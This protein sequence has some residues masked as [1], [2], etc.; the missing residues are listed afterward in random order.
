VVLTVTRLTAI[1]QNANLEESLQMKSLK[2]MQLAK[3]RL[4]FQKV[5]T[6]LIVEIIVTVPLAE[7]EPMPKLRSLPIHGCNSKAHNCLLEIF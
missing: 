3:S 6:A 1:A 5:D 7:L 2:N 4:F